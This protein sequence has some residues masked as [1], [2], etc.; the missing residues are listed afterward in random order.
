METPYGD[1]E[2]VLDLSSTSRTVPAQHPN[3][4]E[5]DFF[6]LAVATPFLAALVS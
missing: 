4:F 1:G 2:C 3:H 6:T 5:I